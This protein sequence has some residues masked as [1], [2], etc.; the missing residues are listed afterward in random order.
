MEKTADPW[1]YM[2]AGEASI[3]GD[4]IFDEAEQT[5]W[6]RA[7]LFGT[8]PYM[9]RDRAKVVRDMMFGKLNLR[10]GDRV[11]VIGECISQCG[12]DEEIRAAI[13]PQGDITAFD[14]APVARAAYA[15][16]RRGKNGELATWDWDYTRDMAA[17]SFDAVAILQAVQHAEDW[18]KT[19]GDLLRVLKKG[20]P[21]LLAEITFGPNLVQ[22]AS[23][24]IHLQ[25]WLDKIFARMG[26]SVADFPYYRPDQLVQAF[27]DK[28]EEAQTFCWRGIELLWGRKAK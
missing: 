19:S 23:L 20:R 18:S 25:S 11:L 3:L 22:A 17:E 12:F 10:P 9:W 6:C 1:T 16:G 27:G 5:R 14:I 15:A 24:D 13:G 2:G 21:I 8:L 28:L 7:I 4:V 26:W